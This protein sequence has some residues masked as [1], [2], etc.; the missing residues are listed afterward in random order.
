M[1]HHLLSHSG[2]VSPVIPPASAP[3][4]WYCVYTKPRQEDYARVHL[5][6]QGLEVFLPKLRQRRKRQGDVVWAIG[7]MFPRYVFIRPADQ[8]LLGKIRST[9]GAVSLVSFGD[10]P[11]MVPDEVIE[12]IRQ[13]CH[14]NVCELTGS[15]FKTGEPVEII[16]G[17][18]AGMT[19]IFHQQTSQRER[20][21]ILLDI[22]ASVARVTIDSRY[23]EK[24]G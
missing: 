18:Y 5:Q 7:P 17:P 20:V 16:G 14:D 1:S 23:L 21:I 15:E 8:A 19:A 4:A 11:A 24:G 3:P 2:H 10:N 9:L 22:M 6:R 12:I 13:H